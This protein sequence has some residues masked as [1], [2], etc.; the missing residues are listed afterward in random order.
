MSGEREWG[1]A[2]IFFFFLA[3]LGLSCGMQNLLVVA[4]C[5]I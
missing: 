2:L 1:V 3:V 5:R 4:S